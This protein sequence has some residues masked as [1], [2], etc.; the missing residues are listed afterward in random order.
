MKLIKHPKIKMKKLSEKSLEN[1]RIDLNFYER[2]NYS[3]HT[4]THT[5]T[6]TYIYPLDAHRGYIY[7]YPLDAHIQAFWRKKYF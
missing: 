2:Q 7:I 3:T 1:S 5:H 4:H 6:H